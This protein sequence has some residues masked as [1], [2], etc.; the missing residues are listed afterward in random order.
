MFADWSVSTLWASWL[1]GRRFHCNDGV[2]MPSQNVNMHWQDKCTHF[3]KEQLQMN[4][5]HT[6]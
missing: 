2:S 1:L 5:V 3:I 4:V 6:T